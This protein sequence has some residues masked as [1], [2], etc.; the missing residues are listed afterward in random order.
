MDD[1]IIIVENKEKAKQVVEEVPAF[2]KSRL[3]LEVNEN[4][5]K[6]FPLNQGVNAIGFKIYTTH[7]LLRNDSKK[8]IKRKAKK[9]GRLLEEGKM[10][11]EK[12][13]QILNSWKGHA[14]N[15]SSYNFIQRL[16]KR[17]DYIYMNNKGV[18]KID[19][20]KITKEGA[21]YDF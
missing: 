19:T 21:G 20:D 17:N 14:D 10:A 4:K 18:L 16:L 12:A 7:R 11:T 8:K 6:I 13:E 9:M 5:T 15:G 3:N 2:I 1:I